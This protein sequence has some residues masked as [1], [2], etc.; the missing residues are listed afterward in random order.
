KSATKTWSKTERIAKSVDVSATVPIFSLSIVTV[1]GKIGVSGSAGVDYGMGLGP[2]I[3][4]GHVT[5][6]VDTKV[7]VQVSVQ[8][9]LD[10]ADAGVEG[11]MTLLKDELELAASASLVPAEVKGKGIQWGIYSKMHLHNTMNM[12]NGD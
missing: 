5:P 9:P 3:V 7:Y 6:F 11:T 1:V 12:L 10:I 4:G 2:G 8:A